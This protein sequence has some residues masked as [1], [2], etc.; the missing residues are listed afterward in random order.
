[1]HF[2]SEIITY[3][4]LNESKKSIAADILRFLNSTNE[5]GGSIIIGIPNKISNH[6]KYTCNKTYE[7]NIYCKSQ[8]LSD[9]Q[10]SP[11]PTNYIKLIN[12]FDFIEIEVKPG[13][14][15]PYIIKKTK[16]K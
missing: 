4:D 16:E 3:I 11:D 1:M 15:K 6:K 12:F 5:F 9:F 10:I 7:N 14:L 13:N 8:I 2:H